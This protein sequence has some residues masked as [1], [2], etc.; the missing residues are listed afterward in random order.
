MRLP[1]QKRLCAPKK[2]LRGRKPCSF[3]RKPLSSL[4]PEGHGLFNLDGPINLAY[5]KLVK[6]GEKSIALAPSGEGFAGTS[7]ARPATDAPKKRS[8][9]RRLP[10][11]PGFQEAGESAARILRT[12]AGMET[13]SSSRIWGFLGTSTGSRDPAM[14]AVRPA[15]SAA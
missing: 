9:P 14:P 15:F 3:A 5:Y 6:K 11:R 13:V 10:L 4:P 12:A 8:R 7:R 2:P 1:A